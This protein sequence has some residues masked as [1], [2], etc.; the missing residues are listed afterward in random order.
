MRGQE[1][2]G[3]ARVRSAERTRLAEFEQ[4]G[5]VP[6]GPWRDVEARIAAMEHATLAKI[7]FGAPILRITR[8]PKLVVA[9]RPIPEIAADLRA[10]GLILPETIRDDDALVITP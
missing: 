4:D 8:Q 7:A 2:S 9:D 10:R 5:F 3:R 6:A 1:G